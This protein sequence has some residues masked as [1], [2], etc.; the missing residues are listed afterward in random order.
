MR[1]GLIIFLILL[2]GQF[3]FATTSDYDEFTFYAKKTTASS[4]QSYDISVINLYN[5]NNTIEDLGG[6]ERIPIDVQDLIKNDFV[7]LFKIKISSIPKNKETIYVY[8]DM[9]MFNQEVMSFER[10]VSE[11]WYNETPKPNSSH[12]FM[13]NKT[14]VLSHEFEIKT[15]TWGLL[16]GYSYLEEYEIK[17]RIKAE[18]GI[19]FAESLDYG[20]DS[21]TVTVR[22]DG[23]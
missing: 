8:V 18:D 2:V 11:K 21:L 12:F 9:Q 17:Y 16:S 15:Y 5:T 3:C 19:S 23:L 22:C 1:K 4:S 7:D 10:Q 20:K 14:G 6:N 13:T